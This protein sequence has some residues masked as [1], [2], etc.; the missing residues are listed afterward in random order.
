MEKAG[1]GNS[2]PGA[3]TVSYRCKQQFTAKGKGRVQ[4]ISVLQIAANAARWAPGA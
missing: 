1:H 2:L 4:P 3:G